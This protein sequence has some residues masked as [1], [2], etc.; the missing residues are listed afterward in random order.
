MSD[1][2]TQRHLMLI[3]HA[4]DH[5][6][7][8]VV[9]FPICPPEDIER[10]LDEL[11]M[12]GLIDS[13]GN[14][15]DEGFAVSQRVFDD[16]TQAE[17]QAAIAA[18]DAA[19]EQAL[20]LLNLVLSRPFRVTSLTATDMKQCLRSSD[21]QVSGLRLLLALGAAYRAGRADAGSLAQPNEQE[22]IYRNK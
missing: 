6:H 7:G 3:Q 4:I 21:V 20:P 11:E 16:A 12:H 13:R 22:Q 1:H 5:Q 9:E 18:E 8:R 14:V 19:L 15:T 10:L 2:P 17:R